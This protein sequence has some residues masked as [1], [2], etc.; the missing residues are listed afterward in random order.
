MTDVAANPPTQRRKPLILHSAFARRVSR[1]ALHADFP[2]MIALV[3]F[4]SFHHG[5][6][7]AVSCS[8]SATILSPYNHPSNTELMLSST[9]YKTASESLL[10]EKCTCSCSSGK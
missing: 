2:S 3:Y 1:P 10:L 7:V 5:I 9:P 4:Q 6:L 8:C